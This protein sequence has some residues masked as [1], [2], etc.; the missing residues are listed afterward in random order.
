MSYRIAITP[1]EPAGIGPD[2]CIKVAQQPP[3]GIELVLIADP[4]LFEARAKLLGL[5]LA[6]REF[7]ADK[8]VQFTDTAELSIIPVELNTLCTP[9][10][11]DAMNAG[12]VLDTLRLAVQQIQAHNLDALVTGPV[13]KGIINEAGIKFSGHTEFLADLCEQELTVMMLATEGLRVALATT[14]LPLAEV[15]GAIT[16]DLLEKILTILAT[17]LRQ[18]FGLH[19]PRIL[20]C[21]L[22]PHAGEGGHLGMEEIEIIEPVLQKKRAQGLDLIGPLPAD[23]LFTDNYLSDADAVLAMYHDQGLPVLKFKGFGNA[24]NITLGLPL[25]RTSVD[26]GTALE[27]AGSGNAQTGSLY[28]AIATAVEMA[29]HWSEHGS[30][31][32]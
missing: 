7:I 19:N 2:L 13:H 1:G 12:Y 27:L 11:L 20:V 31:P 16:Q 8:P 23:T 32:S 6:L 4:S 3:P 5:P 21:G 30:H 15:A 28:N 18:K 25:I 22:N 9:G 26:H 24:S 14:H 10:Q 29:G 17:D